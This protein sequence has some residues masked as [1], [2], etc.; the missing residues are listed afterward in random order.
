MDKSSLTDNSKL[1]RLLQF[2]SGQAN[3][4]IKNCAILGGKDGYAKAKDILEKRF[5]EPNLVARSIIGNLINGKTLT[6]KD[7]SHFS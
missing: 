4:A 3:A 6:V 5:G 7:L 2:T 1:A